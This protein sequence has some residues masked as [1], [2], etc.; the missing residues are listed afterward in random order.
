[1]KPIEFSQQTM[2]W[3]RDQPEYLPLP[4]YVDERETV[5]KWRLTWPERVRMLL[6]GRLWLHQ[7]NFGEPLQ[8]QLPTLENPFRGEIR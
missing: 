6:T 8:P 5:T 4:A 1:M 7:L 2:V 3:A